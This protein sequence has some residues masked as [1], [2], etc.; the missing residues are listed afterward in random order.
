MFGSISIACNVREGLIGGLGRRLG[1]QI[2]GSLSGKGREV[3][4]ELRKRMINVC[5]L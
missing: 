2:T 3:C 5:C 4:D 1:H